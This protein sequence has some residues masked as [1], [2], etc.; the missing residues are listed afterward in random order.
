MGS[1]VE[2]GSNITS[3]TCP[4]C[5]KNFIPTHD[6]AYKLDREYYCRY[7]CYKQAGG[8]GNKIDRRYTRERAT[9]IKRG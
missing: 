6:W 3:R 4:I 9:N 8:D 7:N 1:I 2:R 5:G